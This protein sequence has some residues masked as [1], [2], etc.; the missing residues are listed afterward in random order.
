MDKN[1]SGDNRLIAP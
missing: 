1:Y